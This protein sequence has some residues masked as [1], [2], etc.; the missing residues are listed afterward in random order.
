[1]RCA[2]L[3]CRL[4]EG[5]GA[6]RTPTGGRS[7]ATSWRPTGSSSA[8]RH[9]AGAAGRYPVA[10]KYDG[11]CEGTNP[12]TCNEGSGKAAEELLGPATRSAA[13]SCAARSGPRGVRLPRSRLGHGRRGGRRV[14]RAPGLVDLPR[15][16]LPRLVPGHLRGGS[17][18]VDPRTGS[19][20]GQRARRLGALRRR[21]RVV[22]TAARAAGGE[23]RGGGR[24]LARRRRGA[25]TG[26]RRRAP[27]GTPS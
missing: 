25:R 21:D 19:R 10:M 7:S 4:G 18:A 1:M 3:T 23:L 11:D 27:P 6:R 24:P 16:D 22:Q 5:R 12:L 14:R 20:R 13:S 15:R 2:L 9:A 8:T 26:R 17:R